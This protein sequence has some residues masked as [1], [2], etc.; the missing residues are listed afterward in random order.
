LLSSQILDMADSDRQGQTLIP[1]GRLLS[2][3]ILNMAD[4][5]YNSTVYLFDDFVNELLAWTAANP[6][7]LPITIVIHPASSGGHLGFACIGFL[8]ARIGD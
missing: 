3:Q 1:G 2:C 7:H 5:D 8:A 6:N 4:W